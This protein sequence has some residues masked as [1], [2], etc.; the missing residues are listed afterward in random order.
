MGKHENLTGAERTARRRA[1][2]R[3]QGLRPKQIWLPDLRDPAVRAEFQREGAEINRRDDEAE[4]MTWLESL[5]EEIWTNEAEY[6]WGPGGPPAD[7][8]GKE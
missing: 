5:Q 4:V 6:D 8:R 3:A 2:L 1:T 7:A